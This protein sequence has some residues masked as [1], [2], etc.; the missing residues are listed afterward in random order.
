MRKLSAWS[1]AMVVG[2]LAAV[3]WVGGCEWLRPKVAVDFEMSISSGVSPLP[4]AFTP[5]VEGDV[6]ASYWDFGDGATS[7][8]ARP[9]HVYRTAGT[10]TVALTVTLEDGCVGTSSKKDCVRVESVSQKDRLTL[11]YWLD[12][13][14]GTIYRGDRAG[15]GSEAIVSYVYRGQDLAVGKGF[16]YWTAD[17]TLHR[18]NEDGTD[19]KAIATN[20][21]GLYS[22]SIDDELGRIYWTCLRS[23]P[24][25]SSEWLGA[26]KRANLD[27]SGVAVLK[28]YVPSEN[29]FAWWIRCD[30]SGERY[31]WLMGEWGI[32]APRDARPMSL[33]TWSFQWTY[34]HE[35][36]PHL[37]KGS[38]CDMYAMALDVSDYPANSIYWTTGSEIRRCRVDGSDAI[39]VLGGLNSARGIAVDLG[40]GKM[41]WSDHAGIHRA[42]LDATEAQLIYPGAHADVL[43]IQR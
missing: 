13:D 12:E 23:S 43:V 28:T 1:W 16:V 27:G 41:Y 37:V 19:S 26:V 3:L 21:A 5:I 39:T 32:V 29:E 7:S 36:S 20:Q 30:G 2:A 14:D 34:V 8:E 11:L 42:N 25:A 9:V 38:M 6:A 18:A 4:V 35:F 17:T 31:Y 33:C 40:E 24:L 22:V 10:Y 15:M